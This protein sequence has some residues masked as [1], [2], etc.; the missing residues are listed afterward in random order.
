MQGGSAD[1]RCGTNMTTD[2]PAAPDTASAAAA[3]PREAE[4][5]LP[6]GLRAEPI[7]APQPVHRGLCI[8]GRG[9]PHTNAGRIAPR[10]RRGLPSPSP[11]AVAGE[12][13]RLSVPRDSGKGHEFARPS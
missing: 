7:V 10:I 2:Q 9:I 5:R 8:P 6:A 13:R 4:R 12:K 3:V 1:G 11:I